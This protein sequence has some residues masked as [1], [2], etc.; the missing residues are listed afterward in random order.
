MPHSRFGASL[1]TP[2]AKPYAVTVTMPLD[3][4]DQLASRRVD[5]LDEAAVKPRGR[6]SAGAGVNGIAQLFA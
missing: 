2:L 6:V 4:A 1:T 5:H 3:E